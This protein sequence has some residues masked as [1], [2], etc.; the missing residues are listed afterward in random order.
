MS[1]LLDANA[2][3]QWTDNCQSVKCLIRQFG[4][5]HE[6][7]AQVWLS[8]IRAKIGDTYDVS[9]FTSSAQTHQ[10]LQQT[11][12]ILSKAL[13]RTD[14]ELN[15]ESINQIELD[16]CRTFPNNRTFRD[17]DGVSILLNRMTLI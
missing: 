14:L 3:K 6:L 8:M 16:I 10:L 7:R 11:N 9:P 4:I 13:D 1:R 12:Q 15:S 2:I 17:I 5:P